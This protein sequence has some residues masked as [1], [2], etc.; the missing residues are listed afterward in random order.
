MALALCL[1]AE[2]G[3]SSCTAA[4][5]IARIA[6]AALAAA[7]AALLLKTIWAQRAAAA[8]IAFRNALAVRS[9]P[10]TFS[11]EDLQGIGAQWGVDTRTG[12][13]ED[14]K[15]AYDTFIQWVMPPPD[16]PLLCALLPP[17]PVLACCLLP[18]STAQTQL[19]ELFCCAS[20]GLRSAQQ[21]SAIHLPDHILAMS[22]ASGVPL[23]A[24]ISCP[25]ISHC[26]AL[27]GQLTTAEDIFLLSQCRQGDSLA[28]P[29]D[30]M[31]MG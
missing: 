29:A 27:P 31:C 12:L 20:G 30:D 17:G 21:L 14:R 25:R 9:D 10:S 19:G 3:L 24:N 13:V 1:L 28:C 11:L 18:L 8:A 5:H 4:P 26:S 7:A 16:S 23:M 15:A 22:L 6:G 2:K